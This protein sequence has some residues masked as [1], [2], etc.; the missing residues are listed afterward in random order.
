MDDRKFYLL[1]KNDQVKR[2]KEI[3]I[4]FTKLGLT[5]FGGPAAHVAMMED[6]IVGKR[7]WIERD[8][9]LD[10]YGATNLLP[11]PN[12]TELAIH[13]GL[14]RGG[15][16]G[17]IIAGTCFILPAFIIVTALAY[18][19]VLYGSIPEISG[20]MYGIKPV[21]F[22]VIIQALIRLGKSA[23]KDRFL[24]ILGLMVMILSFLG[25][26]EIFLLLMAGLIAMFFK[27]KNK[28]KFNNMF[29]AVPVMPVPVFLTQTGAIN[30]M[31]VNF[32]FL[33]F[34]RIGSFLYGSGY[35]LLA[36]LEAE[37]VERYGVITNQQLLDAVSIG[38]F[39]PGPMFTTA[40]F[41]GYL[42]NGIP[43]AV[44]AT[45]GIFLPAF[46][47]V[48]LL[49]NVIPKLRSSSWVSGI[50]DGVNVASLGLMA[51]VTLKLGAAALLDVPT[52][53]LAIIS[54]FL[55]FK[56]KI[57]SAWLILFGGTIG[58]LITVIMM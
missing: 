49:N 15:W 30:S 58:L 14:E 46:V 50:L 41:I 34:L 1:S 37:F 8:K 29:L 3:A 32:I 21:V 55:V 2:L 17:L 42:I 13:L 47:L 4:V 52:I 10:F 53:I 35:V 19:Y 11:G 22:A 36:F 16:K 25:L 26:H 9:F 38:Q 33:S 12:S 57:N 7:K 48:G 31:S 39:T 44:V 43:G 24:G 27:N 51:V 5:A 56:Y 28:L 40:T 6:E 23:V 18:V 45:I 54:I 20:I